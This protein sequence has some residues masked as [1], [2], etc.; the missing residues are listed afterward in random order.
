MCDHLPETAQL[1]FWESSLTFPLGIKWTRRMWYWT[2]RT[3]TNHGPHWQHEV[4]LAPVTTCNISY[5]RLKILS[6]QTQEYSCVS[7]WS[8]KRIYPV[9][10]LFVWGI[11]SYLNIGYDH[12]SIIPW[13]LPT[14]ALHEFVLELHQEEGFPVAS[15]HAGTKACDIA[16][17]DTG[18]ERR[19]YYQWPRERA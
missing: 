11:E 15:L 8:R 17:N 13:Y 4:N 1:E 7:L 6:W 16:T 10:L 12:S 9:G 19:E 5:L 2:P 14:R 3:S 18:P